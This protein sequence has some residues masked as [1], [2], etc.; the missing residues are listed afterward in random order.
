MSVTNANNSAISGGSSLT[1]ITG[2]VKWTLP[3]NLAS[4]STYIF[5]LGKGGTYLPFSLVNP[6]TGAGV[7]TAQAEAFTADPGGNI[8]A[9]LAAKS[10]TEYWSLVTTGN[11][12]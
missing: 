6:T 9:T 1:F 12:T 10:A 7:L 2:P 3:S 11:F 5:P 4:G 8:D